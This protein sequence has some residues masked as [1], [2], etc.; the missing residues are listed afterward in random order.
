M[1]E[2]L[3]E[4]VRLIRRDEFTQDVKPVL[5]KRSNF[6]IKSN[7]LNS[8]LANKI[9]L[10]IDENGDENEYAWDR[11]YIYS[12]QSYEF[13][14]GESCRI[15]TGWT[16]LSYPFEKFS[17]ELCLTEYAI[18][19]G[20]ALINPN[21]DNLYGLEGAADIIPVV[22]NTNIREVIRVDPTDDFFILRLMPKCHFFIDTSGKFSDIDPLLH[23]R[24]PIPKRL[25]R[26]IL[27]QISFDSL[28]NSEDSLDNS[29]T[30]LENSDDNM[31]KTFN[32]RNNSE[33]NPDAISNKEEHNDEQHKDE[34]HNDEHKVEQHN[35]EH[36]D[37]EY[38]NEQHN[39]ETQ[40]DQSKSINQN[41]ESINQSINQS[42]EN[43][44]EQSVK[45][46]KVDK[47]QSKRKENQNVTSSV[48][49]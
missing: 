33:G 46:K 49:H 28:E 17:L 5:T 41:K 44:N 3:G 34:H 40:V 2:Q 37:K 30:C 4:V 16:I 45:E 31:S 43:I 35:D 47:A 8:P 38:N 24:K 21:L 25:R 36:H 22:Y 12:R 32:E 48:P 6:Y 27:K 11:W 29:E 39:D 15:Q 19:R 9:S 20:I 10:R 14:P 26:S 13:V 23:F 1:E 7:Y 42:K 18:R